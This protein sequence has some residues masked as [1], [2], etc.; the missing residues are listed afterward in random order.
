MV[1]Q[2]GLLTHKMKSSLDIKHFEWVY[3]L[4]NVPCL[5]PQVRITSYESQT[6]D[7]CWVELGVQC[8]RNLEDQS[9]PMQ[10]LM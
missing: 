7:A 9:F 5:S 6:Q 1:I 3:S 8:G 2:T 10:G 4:R